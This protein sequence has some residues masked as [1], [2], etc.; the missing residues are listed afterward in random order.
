M[1]ETELLN[2]ALNRH[3][4]NVDQNVERHQAMNLSGMVGGSANLVGA[5]SFALSTEW[6][7]HTNSVS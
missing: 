7:C 6:L 1:T 3:E 4:E 2:Q 5:E